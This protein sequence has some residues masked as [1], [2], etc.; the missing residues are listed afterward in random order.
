MIIS[1]SVA[2]CSLIFDAVLKFSLLISSKI[3]LSFI[4]QLS[5]LIDRLIYFRL[6]QSLSAVVFIPGLVDH[7]N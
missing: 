5:L 4:S 7:Y 6:Y 2:S 1:I 3:E